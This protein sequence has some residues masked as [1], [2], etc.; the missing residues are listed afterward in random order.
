M[1]SADAAKQAVWLRRLLED[2]GL[3]LGS[4]PL[5][6]LNKN[7][8]AIAQSRN[9]VNHERSKHIDMRHHFIRE[10]VA[11]KTISLEHVP[12]VGNLA[13]LLTKGLPTETFTQLCDL[14]GMEKV[15]TQKLDQ[16]GVLECNEG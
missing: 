6:L 16:G 13:D 3:G 14:L 11:D 10:K 2:V 12:S 4:S 8:G 15:E 5:Q 7:A 9:P 1:A